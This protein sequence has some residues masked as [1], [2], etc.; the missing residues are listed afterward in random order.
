VS[1][2]YFPCSFALAL[3]APGLRLGVK[4]RLPLRASSRGAPP[5]A[6]NTLPISSGFHPRDSCLSFRRSLRQNEIGTTV[7]PRS[8]CAGPLR[9]PPSLTKSR[10]ATYGHASD[11]LDKTDRPEASL[12]DF[13]PFPKPHSISSHSRPRIFHLISSSATKNTRDGRTS[14]TRHGLSPGMCVRSQPPAVSG[15]LNS[16]ISQI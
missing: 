8:P 4:A 2:Q 12:V 14:D 15:D 16:R 5:G 7:L 1:C 10:A 11:S 6:P 13:T 9:L 3:R